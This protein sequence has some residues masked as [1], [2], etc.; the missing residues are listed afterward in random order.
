M[1]EFSVLIGGRAGFGI[2][3]ASL[4]ISSIISRLGYRIYVNR[5]YPSLIRGGHTFSIIRASRDKVSAHRDSID[6][7]LALNQE[8]LDL[9]KNRLVSGNVLICDSDAVDTGSLT[10]IK[11]IIKVPITGI[12]KELSAEEIMRNT[13]IV[14]AFSRSCGIGWDIV[15]SVFKKDL[16]KDLERN[17]NV[18]R[19]GYDGSREV[20]NVP[21]LE[22]GK[23]PIVTGNEA[24]ALGLVKAGLK[25]YIAYPMTP[26]S[27]ILHYLAGLSEELGIK[28]IHPES[29]ISVIMMALGMAYS[30]ERVAVG[31]SGGGFCLM[32]EGLSFAGMAEL[33]VVI[34]LGQRPGPSTG[35]P[36]YSCQTELDFA[37][38]AGHGE[39][40]RFI[41]APGDAEEAYYAAQLAM[42]LSW[43]YQMPSIILTD[44]IL[45]EGY[46]S[47]DIS[48]CKPINIDG[49][50]LWDK[51]GNY[52]RYF[53]TTTGVSPLAFP[54]EKG[55]VVKASSY[56]HDETGVT[57]ESALLT[58]KMQD[59]RLRKE[60]YLAKEL[61][62][63]DCVKVYGDKKSRKAIICWG[64]N[65]GVCIEVAASLGLK[66]I[67]PTVMS[68][69]PA[70]QLKSA[71][72]GVDR[73]VAVENNAT[74]QLARLISCH[75]RKADSVI[76]KYDG[77]SFGLEELEAKMKEALA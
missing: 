54:S 29:E 60:R 13:C 48:K 51:T 58:V 25:G 40:T 14:G 41:V 70:A 47:F 77:R 5:D 72:E 52:N 31:T 21:G 74:G 67:Q 17:L 19:R 43:K 6:I 30:G 66:V 10:G 49:P 37:L 62:R 22:K 59:K 57:T 69:F 53:D 65:K 7:L 3:K 32:T 68:P 42:H 27:A 39:F 18:A 12:V 44:K 23:L 9:H 73:L 33:P 11:E 75:G 4:V 50:A 56:E 35:L 61:E 46:F 38:S 45:A 26:S 24:T 55:A 16:A 20:F 64:S 2:D 1:N 34:V 76:L 63:Y 71:L 15:E 28:V 36:T 8:T